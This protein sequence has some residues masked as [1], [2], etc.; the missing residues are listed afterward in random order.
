VSC[1]FLTNLAGSTA[2]QSLPLPPAAVRREARRHL[3]QPQCVQSMSAS[4]PAGS[5]RQEVATPP[6][7]MLRKPA[8]SLFS[9]P[10]STPKPRTTF[11]QCLS[12]LRAPCWVMRM[13][14]PGSCPPL[15][16]ASGWRSR[17]RVHHPQPFCRAVR[18]SQLFLYLGH[19]VPPGTG[20][21]LLLQPSRTNSPAAPPPPCH[22]P[23]PPPAEVPCSSTPAPSPPTA[24]AIAAALLLPGLSSGNCY[25]NRP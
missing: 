6:R 18:T 7:L 12:S 1:P 3:A 15:H 16:S 24:S 21:L 25:P 9:P 17:G 13:G 14:N 4:T 11:L 20:C 2:V 19:P 10:A 5:I 8:L 22:G 23:A